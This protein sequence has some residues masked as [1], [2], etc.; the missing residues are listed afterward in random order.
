M[1]YLGTGGIAMEYKN[2]K[3][4][5]H[6]TPEAIK[7]ARKSLMLANKWANDVAPKFANGVKAVIVDENTAWAL[8]LI[9]WFAN[10]HPPLGGEERCLACTALEYMSIV[11]SCHCPDCGK[12]LRTMVDNDHHACNNHCNV[13]IP[14]EGA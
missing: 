6:V 11:E 13:D 14:P 7:R 4:V 12:D 8:N 1:V 10:R 2:E 3:T 5:I 9:G